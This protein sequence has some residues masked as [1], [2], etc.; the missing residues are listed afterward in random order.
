MIEYEIVPER[1]PPSRLGQP[2]IGNLARRLIF[3]VQRRQANLTAPDRVQLVRLRSLLNELLAEE[4][5]E[6]D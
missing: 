6:A 4:S 2:R 5:A 1:T 3:A